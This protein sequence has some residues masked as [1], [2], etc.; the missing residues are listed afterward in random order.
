MITEDHEDWLAFFD[1]HRAALA[2]YAHA[3][4]G[5]P[6]DAAD[7]VQDVLVSMLRRRRSV[8]NSLAYV[9]GAMRHRSIDLARRASRARGALQH[10]K[11]SCALAPG[12]DDALAVVRA[13]DSLPPDQAEV[14]VLRLRSGLAFEEIASVVGRPLGTVTS[15]YS[16]AIAALRALLKDARHEART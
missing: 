16:R 1:R 3:L 10:F 8:R 11:P 9:L 13:L 14:V 6:Q 2:A 4:C 12:D 5:C 15:Q 7:L